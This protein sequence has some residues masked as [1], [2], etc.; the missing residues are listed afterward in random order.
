MRLEHLTIAICIAALPTMAAAQSS[1]AS[2]AVP[3]AKSAPKAHPVYTTESTD[4]GTLL[5]D[6]AAKAVLVKR[7]PDLVNNDQIEMARG[8]TLRALQP[9][10]GEVLTDEVLKNIDADLAALPQPK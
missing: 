4:L 5:D 9:Y 3:A 6:P 2:P 8:M 1:T 7:V 10:A